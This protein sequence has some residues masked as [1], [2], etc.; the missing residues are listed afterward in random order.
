MLGILVLHKSKLLL[1]ESKNL[2]VIARL[3]NYMQSAMNQSQ[4]PG[5]HN[6]GGAEL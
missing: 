4:A 6:F 3:D 1:P 2:F 5:F